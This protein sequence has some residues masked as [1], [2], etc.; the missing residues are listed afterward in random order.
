MDIVEKIVWLVLIVSL[1]SVGIHAAYAEDTM[2]TLGFEHKSNPVTCIMEPPPDIQDRFHYSIFT[3]TYESV[4]K[5]SSD[6]N[7]FTEGDWYIPMRYYEHETHFDKTPEDFPECNIFIEYRKY[8]GSDGNPHSSET[9]L[10][11]TSFDFSKSRH[12][13]SYVMVFFEIPQENPKISLCIG[14]V[15]QDEA[16]ITIE[17]KYVPVPD[18]AVNRVI[19]HEFGHALG[20]GHYIEDRNKSNN[21]P[22]LMYPT[23]NPFGDNSSVIETIDK[24]MLVKLYYK[25]GFS[26]AYGVPPR[27]ISISDL[28][29]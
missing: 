29:Q 23:L 8:N 19:M 2:D 13:F 25:D 22:S 14:C 16:T 21:E 6:M 10:G 28:I 15:D 18:E 24:E 11:Y 20:I 1:L 5:W 27:S 7:D 3:M 4:K 17:K 9:A 12:G 26:G